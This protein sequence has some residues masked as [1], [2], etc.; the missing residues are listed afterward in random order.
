M[1][2]ENVEIVRAHV[3]AFRAKDTERSASFLDEHVVQD[4]ARVSALEPVSYGIE[5]IVK[6]VVDRR[7]AF[8]DYDYAVELRDLGSGQV[9]AEGTESG[10]GKGSGAPVVR[11]F[12]VLYTVLSGKI[13]RITT[14]PSARDALE[15]MGLSE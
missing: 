14:F 9:L 4:L 2:Q 13:V 1:S 3:E 12:A 10:R 8:D 7:G 15:A 5:A 11:S 6:D